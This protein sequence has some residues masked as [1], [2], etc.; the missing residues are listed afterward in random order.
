MIEDK[1]PACTEEEIDA[2]VWP[3]GVDGKAVK[4][5][6][7][8]LNDHG[9]DAMRYGAMYLERPHVSF[10]DVPQAETERSRWRIG[11]G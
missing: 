11:H 9:M 2:Y 7:V 3:K 5:Q 1:K 10:D 4:E 8:K 6:P